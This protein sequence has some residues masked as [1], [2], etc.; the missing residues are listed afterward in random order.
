[1]RDSKGR[2]IRGHKP[3]NPRDKT[4]GKFIKKSMVKLEDEY[5]KKSRELNEF[6]KSLEVDNGD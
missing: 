2:F 1:M 4:T 6:L 5:E 3:S